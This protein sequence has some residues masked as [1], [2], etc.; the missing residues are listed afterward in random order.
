MDSNFNDD[1]REIILNDSIRINILIPINDKDEVKSISVRIT[2]KIT[3]YELLK[4]AIDM[5]NEY[6]TKQNIPYELNKSLINYCKKPV[7]K[8]ENLIMIYQVE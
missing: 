7:R 6:F 4:G 5:F 1:S 8:A 3:M 2:D